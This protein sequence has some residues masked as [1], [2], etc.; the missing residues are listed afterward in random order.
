MTEHDRYGE[1]AGPYALGILGIDERGEF[2]SH[3]ATCPQCHREFRE[4]ALVA[5]CLGRVVEPQEPPADLRRRVLAA[6]LASRSPEVRPG[7]SPF[8]SRGARKPSA[9]YTLAP[10]LLAAAS[11]AVVAL[12]L[13]SWSL[14]RRLVE[15]DAALQQAQARLASVESQIASLRTVSDETT[16]TADVL[17]AP[18][19][20]RVE[21]T[22]QADAPRARGRAFWSPSRGLVLAA[23]N[24]PALPQGRVY[25]LWVLTRSAKVS[26]GLMRPDDLGRLRGA[27]RVAGLEAQAIA[28]TMEPEGGVP[29]P[30]GSIYMVGAL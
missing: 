24:L 17:S 23:N 10:W 22:G 29:Q 18:D 27:S 21:L 26:A 30:T 19:V 28:L 25:Q 5:E 11:F 7:P 15:T 9:G 6:A 14:H 4:V 1:L 13:Y 20:V 8:Q 2:D 3:L 12:G 16:Q